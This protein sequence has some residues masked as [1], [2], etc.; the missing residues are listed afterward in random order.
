MRDDVEAYVKTCLVCQQD[1]VEHQLP[2]G[3]L[4]PLPIPER[5][6]ESVSMDFIVGLP[7]SEGCAWILVVVDRFSKYGVFIPAPKDCTAEQAAQLFLKH[8]VKH[9]GLPKTIVSDRDPRFTGRFWTELFKLLGTEL[10]FSTAMHP[11]SNRKGKC[12]IGVVFEALC[13]R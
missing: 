5:P 2:T 10:N 7:S 12:A 1:K 4:E 8:V 13:E 11:R 6:W 9:W 3:L